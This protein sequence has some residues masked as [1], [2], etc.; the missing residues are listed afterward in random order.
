MISVIVPVF[1][2]A[3]WIDQ[4]IEGLL[5]QDL[6]P[7]EYEIILVDNNSSDDSKARIARYERVCLLEEPVQS[8]YAAR[9]RGVR[10]SRGELLAFTDSDCVAER[11]W[12]SS[13]WR[14]MRK[15]RTRLVLGSRGAMPGSGI[16][17]LLASYD[18]ARVQYILENRRKNSYFGFTNNMAVRREA[19]DE[20]GP[21][22]TVARGSDTA[23]VRRVADGA[24]SDSVSWSGEIRVRHLELC[25]SWTYIKKN[26]L[27]ARARRRTRLLE[28]YETL[29][30]SESFAIFQSVCRGRRV[31]EKLS[32]ALA[33]SM[34]RLS[35]M[36]GS[37]GVNL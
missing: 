32:L 2:A 23:F 10:E 25:N 21:F 17:G 1:N 5:N 3:R 33:L 6:D 18:D 8:S 37:L 22:E 36:V 30:P 7:A 9:N 29:Q 20:Y 14:A 24:G 35:W 11:S 27:Y 19:F 28:T 12:L 16:V 13:I 15:E 4:C 31:G 34:G 26:F